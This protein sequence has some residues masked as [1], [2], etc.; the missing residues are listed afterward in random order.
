MFEMNVELPNHLDS[1][2]LNASNW[3]RSETEV[4]HDIVRLT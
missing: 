2:V 4:R 3:M 1:E